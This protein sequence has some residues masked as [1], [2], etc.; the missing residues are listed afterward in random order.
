MRPFARLKPTSCSNCASSPVLLADHAVAVPCAA[1][2]R[3]A[4]AHRRDPVPTRFDNSRSLPRLCKAGRYAAAMRL[5]LIRR[6][7]SREWARSNAGCMPSHV[8]G[9]EPNAFESPEG[10][11]LQDRHCGP[12]RSGCAEVSRHSPAQVT[13]QPMVK[14]V[15]VSVRCVS[16]R[17]SESMSWSR[18][19]M[20]SS[21]TLKISWRWRRWRRSS[22]W[23]FS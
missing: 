23:I 3:V 9:V 13:S 14:S 11:F 1:V 16:R 19:S 18:F 10:P 15:S 22:F 6:S 21:S 2:G 20:I 5:T 7:R 17:S 8:S 4:G 12:T